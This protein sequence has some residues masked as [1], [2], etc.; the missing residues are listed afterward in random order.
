LISGVR[1]PYQYLP[2]SVSQF[3]DQESLAVAITAA[4][5]ANVRYRNLTGGVAALHLGEKE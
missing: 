5:F 1:G 2:D 3:P 4:G